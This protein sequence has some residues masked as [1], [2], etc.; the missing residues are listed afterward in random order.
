MTCVGFLPQF[1]PRSRSKLPNYFNPLTSRSLTW[2]T[3]TMPVFVYFIHAFLE[4]ENVLKSVKLMYAV[5]E[6]LQIQSPKVV[7]RVNETQ[8]IVVIFLNVHEP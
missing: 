8:L 4:I 6:F 3:L 5:T 2:T 7:D 1:L